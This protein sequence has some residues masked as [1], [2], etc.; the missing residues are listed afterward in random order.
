[1]SVLDDVRDSLARL[2][3]IHRTI[4]CQPGMAEPIREL[5]AA[6]GVTGL[7]DVVESEYVPT[8]KV[9]VFK[10]LTTN[11]HQQT[12]ARPP[13]SQVSACLTRR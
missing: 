3:S 11:W 2:E 1:M 4:V 12:S 7:V 5:V 6:E 13:W 9:Y 8:G 10:T